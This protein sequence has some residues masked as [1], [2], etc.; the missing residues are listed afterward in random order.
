[1]VVKGW[2]HRAALAGAIAIP[3]VLSGCGLFS[4]QSSKSIDPPQVEVLDE[5][6]NPETGQAVPEGTETNL[7]VYL[8]DSNGYLAPVAINTTIGSGEK[9]VER[10]LAMMTD[11]GEYAS[12]I[13][14]GFRAMIP[15]GTELKSYELDK[16]RKVA[17]IDFSDSFSGYNVQDERKI[18]ES[19]T[20]TLTAMTGIEGVEIWLEGAKL[21]EMP[22][23]N[24]PLDHVL[25]RDIGINIELASGVTYAESTP[26]TLY[27]SSLTDNNEEYYVPVTR[28][29]A[30][31]EDRAESAM[32]ELIA[33]PINK[34]ELDSVI[35]PEVQVESIEQ[36]DSV[37]VVD[38]KDDAY[39]T[40]QKMPSKMLQAI[41]LSLTENTDAT[42][43]QITFNGE[44]D[45]IDEENTLY[46]EP[47]SRPHHVNALKS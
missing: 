10:A 36:K 17:I 24:Y 44:T 37:V 16:E 39:F 13:P 33:G 11:N 29:V 26:I 45:I 42:H 3:M 25:T 15:Q 30:S 34:K 43:V 23:D 8:E 41:V 1:M 47:V 4:Q 18:V 9:A 38:L 5:V 6:E 22:V 2:F 40:G 35:L 7:T 20:W 28:L 27:F 12:L 19:I 31:S 21:P 14:E 32:K 46:N